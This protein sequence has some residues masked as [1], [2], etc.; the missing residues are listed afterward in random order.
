MAERIIEWLRQIGIAVSFA[1]LGEDT[2]LP[3]L[4]LQAG[5]LV[6]DAGRLKYPGDLLHEAG[7]LAVMTT[8]ERLTA[9][10][11][12]ITDMGDEISAQAWSYAAAVHLGL[13][14]EVVFHPD[15]YR[16]SAARLIEIYAGGRAGVPVLQWMGLTFDS[17]NA[18][19]RN[20]PAYPH[21]IRWL[22]EE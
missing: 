6:V 1:S 9:G 21:M 16:G 7:H 10:S 12:P 17:K 2:F 20:V 22:R 18:A 8:R 13:P 15:G 19:A 4:A 3:G 14:P 5:G 11:R